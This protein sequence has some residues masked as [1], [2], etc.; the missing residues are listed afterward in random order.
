MKQ[1]SDRTFFGVG[2]GGKAGQGER[3]F[4]LYSDFPIHSVHL[5][6][7]RCAYCW[8]LYTRDNSEFLGIDS[9]V[10]NYSLIKPL[11][12]TIKIIYK[13]ENYEGA[14]HIAMSGLEALQ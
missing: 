2:V 11:I 4:S 5:T 10:R 12:L 13:V 8:F 14:L 9:N 1:F 3:F 7:K 6:L